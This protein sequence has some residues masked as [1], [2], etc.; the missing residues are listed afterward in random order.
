MSA[1]R[2]QSSLQEGHEKHLEHGCMEP[3]KKEILVENL[4]VPKCE[5]VKTLVWKL[6]VRDRSLSRRSR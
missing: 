5:E 3:I 2:S 6:L 1:E 4:A